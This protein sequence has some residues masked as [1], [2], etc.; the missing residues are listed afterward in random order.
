MKTEDDET[1]HKTPEVKIYMAQDQS[2][3]TEPIQT[4]LDVLPTFESIG[5]PC[6]S[7]S[8]SPT[9]I[10]TKGTQKEEEDFWAPRSKR[11]RQDTED[12]KPVLHTRYVVG[13]A[14]VSSH[15]ASSIFDASGK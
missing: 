10:E 9:L 2:T 12:V 1:S 8:S 6:V 15:R 14:D 7:I 4:L 3:Q 11:R 13:D 5:Q